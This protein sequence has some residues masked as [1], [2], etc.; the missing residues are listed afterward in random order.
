MFSGKLAVAVIVLI[1]AAAGI[2]LSSDMLPSTSDGYTHVDYVVDGDTIK[3]TD[4]DSIRFLGINTP[5]KGAPHADKAT[6]RLEEL[7]DGAR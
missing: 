4:G 3:T 1:M 2:L 7:L 5:E 6:E